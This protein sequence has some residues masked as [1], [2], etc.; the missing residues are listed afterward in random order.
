MNH[1]PM[2]N[3][4]KPNYN[5]SPY[6]NMIVMVPPA[7]RLK[8]L[9]MIWLSCMV[10]HDPKGFIQPFEYTPSVGERDVPMPSPPFQEIPKKQEPI[11]KGQGQSKS[12]HMSLHMGAQSSP[13]ILYSL[14]SSPP[15]NQN[16]VD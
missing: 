13:T 16:K 8:D 14:F 11:G 12:P 1:E 3:N 9:R 10:Q 6:A 7:G 15:Q 2:S 4:Q 5:D